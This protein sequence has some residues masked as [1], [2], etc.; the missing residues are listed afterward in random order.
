MT[1]ATQRIR[2]RLTLALL[3]V[4]PLPPECARAQST[5][6]IAPRMSLTGQVESARAATLCAVLP[7]GAN[8]GFAGLSVAD[9]DIGAGLMHARVEL[10]PSLT[11]NASVL[12]PGLAALPGVEILREAPD[13]IRFNAPLSSVNQAFAALEYRDASDGDMLDLIADDLQLPPL[14]AEIRLHLAAD[15]KATKAV[16]SPCRPPPDLR[17]ESDT[18]SSDAD[19]ITLAGPLQF[20]VSGMQAGDSVDLLNDGVLV[21]STI[22]AG[23]STV[24]TDPSPVAGLTSLYAVSINGDAGSASW[25]VAV[26]AAEIFANG[27]ETPARR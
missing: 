5:S 13:R 20:D 17:A 26:V 4:L 11:S 19:D 8:L 3:M 14:S 25:S 21:S 7:L 1:P 10:E 23:D 6:N 18:G 2:F 15:P 9:A 12:I 16:F 27:F 22:A 24:V